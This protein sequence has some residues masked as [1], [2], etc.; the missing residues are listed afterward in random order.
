MR[1]HLTQLLQPGSR[2]FIIYGIGQGFNLIT[3]L[4]V[5]PYI[6]SR[7]GL[8]HYGRSAFAMAV[9]FFLIVFVDYGSEILGV[10]AAAANREDPS[11]LGS[12]F[13]INYTSR[14]LVL[15][16]VVAVSSLLFLI[17]PVFS[18]DKPL[19]FLSLPILLGQYLNPT[20]FLQATD[21]ISR[22]SIL[23]FFS[24]LI[25]AAGVLITVNSPADYVLVNLWWGIG[26]IV[27]YGIGWLHLVKK[28]GFSF[29]SVRKAEVSE[30]LKSGFSMFGSQVFVSLQ[31]YAPQMLVGFF[32]TPLMAGIYRVS[33][34]VVVIFR[35]YILLFF[36]FV[37]PRICYLIPQNIVDAMRYW[38]KVNLANFV[39]ICGLLSIVMVFAPQMV[40]Y[41]SPDPN[42]EISALLRIALLIPMLMAVSVPLKQLILG[43]GENRFYIRFTIGSVIIL[44]CLLAAAI[45]LSGLKAAVMTLIFVEATTVLAFAIKLKMRKG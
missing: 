23:N 38:K 21:E 45:R 5:M 8:E 1:K 41:F 11:K 27:A 17:L 22:I 39:F 26:M 33:D 14:L 4:L 20:W 10:R 7:C 25:F 37:F 13:A 40:A 18:K 31:L 15:L 9:F 36:N 16:M 2:K 24:K 19:F 29:S 43:F 42:G 3:P 12:I 35:T 44:V 34:Q 32:G 30:Y 6:I 28:N